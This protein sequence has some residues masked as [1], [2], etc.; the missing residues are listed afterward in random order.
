MQFQKSRHDKEPLFCLTENFIIFVAVYGLWVKT[1]FHRFQNGGVVPPRLKYF[2]H[3]VFV[4]STL[5]V[6]DNVTVK[7]F[8]RHK[9]KF[10]ICILLEQIKQII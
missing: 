10:F 1:A 8:P 9:N 5:P 7:C 6:L 3:S 2:F 4:T